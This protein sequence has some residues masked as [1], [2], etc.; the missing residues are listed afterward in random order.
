M[1]TKYLLLQEIEKTP[2]PLL[3]QIPEFLLFLKTT[4][5]REEVETQADLEDARAA[6]EE[7]K[8]HGISLAELKQEQ[9]N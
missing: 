5:V 9:E 8:Q 7:A 4:Q 1:D 2:E 3:N 6:L